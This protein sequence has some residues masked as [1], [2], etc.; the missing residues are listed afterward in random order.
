MAR[1]VSAYQLG[2]IKSKFD[3]G[4][5]K[6]DA[7]GRFADK[8]DDPKPSKGKRT[9]QISD[10]TIRPEVVKT[11]GKL[12]PSQKKA[13][14]AKLSEQGVLKPTL[15]SVVP[16]GIKRVTKKE[17]VTFTDKGIE[18]W[19]G[20]KYKDKDPT[21]KVR[22]DKQYNYTVM[23]DGKE[24]SLNRNR[25]VFEF[26]GEVVKGIPSLHPHLREMKD[27]DLFKALVST[28]SMAESSS[29]RAPQW[30]SGL[31]GQVQGVDKWT[32][33]LG[34]KNGGKKEGYYGVM[35]IH[36]VGQWSKVDIP[37]FNKDVIEGKISND[38]A[39][40]IFD[41]N[42]KAVPG[43]DKVLEVQVK[44]TA[45]REFVMLPAGIHDAMSSLFAA[46]HPTPINPSKM[47]LAKIGI[48]EKGKDAN[49]GSREWFDKWKPKF[50]QEVYRRESYVLREEITRRIDKGL[51]PL[52]ESKK[53]WDK[54]HSEASS[55]ATIDVS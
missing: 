26:Q 1:K 5:V 20:T 32:Y 13:A 11:F 8:P 44:A 22:V 7:R 24:V 46:N 4:K 18:I 28:M 53:I 37:K 47:K 40:K 25:N 52:S 49:S 19:Q 30:D 34:S 10:F 23:Q 17:H 54:V 9:K 43:R 35:Q 38:E 48:P 27:E 33:N 50:W 36:H 29:P 15:K 45:D 2:K 51:L 21:F 3:E 14:I 6:R 41:D 42:F 39:Q 12:N 31:H 55:S 16:E